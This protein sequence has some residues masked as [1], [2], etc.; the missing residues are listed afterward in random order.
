MVQKS[1]LKIENA[2]VGVLKWVPCA[3]EKFGDLNVNKE[4]AIVEFIL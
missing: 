2:C 4:F 1:Q 3:E